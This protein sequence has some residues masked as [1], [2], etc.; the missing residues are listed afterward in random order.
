[1]WAA[2]NARIVRYLVI[3]AF[4]CIPLHHQ[5]TFPDQP[6]PTLLHITK[7]LLPEALHQKDTDYNKAAY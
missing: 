5:A 7:T 2:G 1:M 3:A 4:V 6:P